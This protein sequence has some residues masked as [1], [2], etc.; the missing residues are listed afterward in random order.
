MHQPLVVLEVER[1]MDVLQMRCDFLQVVVVD[2]FPERVG[3]WDAVGNQV[4][5]ALAVVRLALAR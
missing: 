2:A 1:S 4:D 3:I 5:V